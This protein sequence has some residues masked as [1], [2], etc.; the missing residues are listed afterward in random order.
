T[1]TSLTH[2]SAQ[3]LVLTRLMQ[4]TDKE[5][6]VVASLEFFDTQGNLGDADSI[7]SKF[8]PEPA[9]HL[10]TTDGSKVVFDVTGP[11]GTVIILG[12]SETI[13]RSSQPILPDT[14]VNAGD[15]RIANTASDGTPIAFGDVDDD[16]AV[17]T[18]FA[19]PVRFVDSD[20]SLTYTALE[21]I[22][23]DVDDSRTVNA[24]DLRIANTGSD[25]T[26]VAALDGD[27]GDA[28]DVFANTILFVDAGGLDGLFTSGEAII[29]EV[30]GIGDGF[31]HGADTRLANGQS[32][33]FADNTNVLQG[34]T[35]IDTSL[36]VFTS[37]EK[38]ED[39][40]GSSVGV[41]EPNET[42]YFSTD[43][44][45]NADDIRFVNANTQGFP[46][47][48][49]VAQDSDIG[50]SLISFMPISVSYVD[51]DVSTS[52]TVGEFLYHDIDQNGAVS[53]N[54]IRISGIGAG[55]TV[56]ATDD[57]VTVPLTLVSLVT[58]V[59]FV[60]S[61]TPGFDGADAVY[62]TNG[63][64]VAAGDTRLTHA[65][66]G[67]ADGSLV[68]QDSDIG[69]LLVG[70]NVYEMHDEIG[71]P[72]G[73][74]DTDVSHTYN[75]TVRLAIECDASPQTN[76]PAT[77]PDVSECDKVRID[78]DFDDDTTDET[79]VAITPLSTS[80]LEPV[81]GSKDMNVEFKDVLGNDGTVV[82]DSII[83][84][85][86]ITQYEAGPAGSATTPIWEDTTA[87]TVTLSGIVRQANFGTEAVQIDF[88]YRVTDTTST[89]DTFPDPYTFAVPLQQ[90]TL[91]DCGV[92][93]DECNFSS[94]SEYPRPTK[95]DNDNSGTPLEHIHDPIATL[96]VFASFTPT[97]DVVFGSVSASTG[98]D[99]L[100]VVQERSTSTFLQPILN[101]F[102]TND[103]GVVGKGSAG[104]Q[105]NVDNTGIPLKLIEFDEEKTRD[106]TTV[107]GGDDD[108]GDSLD[109][110]TP[111]SNREVMFVDGGAG[112]AMVYDSNELLYQ[113]R[114]DDGF[115]STND[116][117]IANHGADD[118]T[119][120][121][122]GDDDEIAGAT[123]ETFST[124]V[125]FVDVASPG[126]DAK[127]LLYQDV[128]TSGGVTIGDIRIANHPATI[129]ATQTH[130]GL[131][132]VDDTAMVIDGTVAKL[133]LPAAGTDSLGSIVQTLHLPSFV[134][135]TIDNLGARQVELS[136]TDGEDNVTPVFRH[137]ADVINPY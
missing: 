125:K 23:G 22:Y 55:S 48:S 102:A 40:T 36:V 43:S 11:T 66:S 56:A 53:L 32:Q 69:T 26:T 133:N 123:L 113:D 61:G 18:T 103:F 101:P 110:F 58:A 6:I 16:G 75:R 45:V 13:Y 63:A 107:A 35:D 87:G 99:N 67:F 81:H 24:G 109:S 120:V 27:D 112:T 74:F 10:L 50:A 54:D 60:D 17:L 128:D 79:Y 95:D 121:A 96:G 52:F 124:P 111:P 37:N 136:V 134:T 91:T 15:K 116:I 72:N 130:I 33:G 82:L 30:E 7:T 31:R 118:D 93:V 84:D 21:L 3:Q 122:G 38:H 71:T 25:G 132:I 80:T 100:V 105:D 2:P 135:L 5:G 70:F 85:A 29:E 97:P 51:S 49:I 76:L 114:D 4:S 19:D 129:R 20:S 46:D 1:N 65:P 115:V 88:D 117:R 34:N 119:T 42:G 41:F 57:D 14:K 137:S 104:L 106:G 39:D 98:S 64:N 89:F 68:A 73:L 62:L 28:L 77:S 92:V 47:G 86:I 90:A 78:L 94:S 8:T 9:T 83:L 12:A 44:M 108:V 127:E 131:T 59:Q 126:F